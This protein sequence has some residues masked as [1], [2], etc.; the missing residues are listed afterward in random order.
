MKIN[1]ERLVKHLLF[2]DANYPSVTPKSQFEG[3]EF[4]GISEAKGYGL[5]AMTIEITVKEILDNLQSEVLKQLDSHKLYTADQIK[6]MFD[7]VKEVI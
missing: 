4:K 6:R 7:N 1:R 5:N 3:M 2:G